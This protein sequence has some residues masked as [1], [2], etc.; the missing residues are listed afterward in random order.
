[1][2]RKYCRPAVRVFLPAAFCSFICLTTA[3]AQTNRGGISGNVTDSSGAAVPNASVVITNV[4]TNEIHKL[5]TGSKGSFLQEDLEP[6]MY[7]V[8][9]Q[10]QGF[11]KAVLEKVKVDTSTVVTANVVLEPGNVNTQVTVSANS[12]LLN[13]ESSTLGQTISARTLTDTPLPNRSVLDLAVTVPNVSGDVGTEDPQLAGGPP[14]PGFNL[15]ANGARAGSTHML[16]DGVSNTGVGLGRE[17]VSFAPEDV[18]EL[19][20]Q[21][22]GY[23]AEYGHS[24]GGIVSV[25]TKSGTND[26]NGMLL[27]YL[28]N[29]LTNAAPFT[30]ASV[31]RPVNNLRWNQFDA[32]IGGPVIIPKLYNGRNKTFFFFSAE[33]RYQRDKQQQSAFVPTDAMRSGD[34]SNLVQLNGQSIQAPV[35]LMSQFPASAFLPT[36]NTNIYNQFAVVNNNQFTIAHLATGAT[37]PQFPGNKIPASMLDPVAVQL[38]QKYVPKAN[39]AP[40]LNSNGVLENYVTYQYLLDDSDRYNLRVD[41]NFG[42][43]NHLTFRWTTIP[44]V[45]ISALDPNY[46]TNG[47]SGTYSKSTQYMLSDTQIISPTAVNELRLAY[48]RADFSG[49]L[50]PQFDVKTGENLSTEYGLPSL[51]KG[52]LPLINIYDNSNSVANIGSA[53]STLGYSLEQQY[54]IAD[55]VYI[56]RGGMTWKFG[57]D[58][59][60]AL[61]NDESL[62]SVAGGN[63]QFRYVQTDQTGAA[64]TM[65]QIG[66]SAIASFLLGVPN[67][68]VLANS[69][70]PYYYR[71]NSGGFYVQNDWKVK[72]NFTLNIGLRYS[73]E[74][75]RTELYNHQGFL[76][77]SLAYTVALPKPCPLPDCSASSAALGLGTV[78]QATVIPFAYDGYGGR[79]RYLT[80]IHWL[81]FEPRFGFAYTPRLFGIE[82]WVLRGGYGISHAPLTGLNRNPVPNFTTGAS[83]FGETAGQAN[84][85]Y[86]ERIGTNP[87]VNPPLDVNTALELNNNPTGIVGLGA[88]NFPGIELTG[89]TS[90]PYSQ[91]WSVSIERQFGSKSVLELAYAGSKGTHLFM[92][93]VVLNNPSSSYLA[94]LQNLNVKATTTVTD[95]LGRK[96]PNGGTISP[97]LYTLA[98]PYLGYN[99]ITT[100][101]DASGNSTF[102]AAIVSY[103]YMAGHGL[104]MYT[105]FRWSKSL[106]DASD[107]SPDKQALTTGSVGGGQYSFGGTAAGDKSVSTYNIPYDFNLVGIYDLPYG[108]GRPF[109]ST[110]PYAARFFLGDWTVAGVERLI[111]GYPFTPTIAADNFI[112]TLHTHEI[113]PDIVPGVP[114]VNPSWSV[115]CPTTNQCPSYINFS[116]FELPPA[117]QIGNAPRT[118]SA[119]TGPMVQTLDVSV[120]KTWRI[121]EKRSIQFRVDALNVLNHPVFRNAAD[122]GG[123]T[124]IFG[125]Y[126]SFAWTSA[127]LQTAYN[128]WL[129][130]YDGSNP[131][132]TSA[133][134][135]AFQSMILSQQN[136]RGTLPNDFY[137]VPL[138]ANFG[139]S[140][141]NS[142]DIRDLNG[143]KQYEI[144]QNLSTGGQLTYNPILNPQRY[145]QFG[146]RIYF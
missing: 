107:S 34:F 82:S 129:K 12:S 81:D 31:N 60:R 141:V 118:L 144:R 28:R 43:K 63:Y 14:L 99:N 32:Q 95:P 89:E 66:G 26:Y 111:S 76:D 102:N 50:S 17:V 90:V 100:Y 74:L 132:P 77:P 41:Q 67:S 145:L 44:E 18:Q 23:D 126:P 109:G 140:D 71:W 122:V 65:S 3:I 24:D 120:Q 83:N 51:T 49:Q 15:Q 127:S 98:S 115:N 45:G 116:A 86:V 9:V 68:I 61:L 47:N 1:M 2:H 64:G 135:A 57:A 46:P 4:G 131:K 58:L 53:V 33:P 123:G 55:N 7:R 10:A 106:D 108:E 146:L 72:P 36:N 56:T 6:V 91:N 40:F 27:W 133:N 84:P 138:P 35:S 79:S 105:N 142:Y 97:Y 124:D 29:P 114:V 134:L 21:T 128:S 16:A 96:N 22:N 54:E 88:I 137:T 42:D 80:P 94:D 113:R 143:F 119:A 139:T 25:T 39:T 69:A 78:T 87:P 125:N 136:S 104:T 8:E 62:Y 52:G 38:M 11:K 101:W 70:I 5:T 75:P 112:D 13:T 85:S 117:G 92:P 73:L 130:T 59:S 37:Y 110:A 30:Q 103:K 48:T 19:T 20:V 93:S 121:G